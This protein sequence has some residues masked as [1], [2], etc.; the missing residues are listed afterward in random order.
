MEVIEYMK[1]LKFHPC[2][3]L[4]RRDSQIIINFLTRRYN[5]GKHELVVAVDK[6]HKWGH[7]QALGGG[8][9]MYQHVP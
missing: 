2:P 5:P 3:L 9:T 8:V 4:L 7:E 6:H 1:L